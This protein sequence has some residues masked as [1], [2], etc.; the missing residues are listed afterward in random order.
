MS[1]TFNVKMKDSTFMG[2]ISLMKV[3]QLYRGH[4]L[5]FLWQN[6]QNA[7]EEHPSCIDIGAKNRNG[8]ISHGIAPIVN[9][10][11]GK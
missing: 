1:I 7:I 10:S 2:E 9:I 8:N 4:V 3:L 6:V 5:H 11:G